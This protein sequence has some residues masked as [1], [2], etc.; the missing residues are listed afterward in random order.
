MNVRFLK[1]MIP[2]WRLFA[3]IG[4]IPCLHY[5]VG[6][7]NE[8]GEWIPFPNRSAEGGIND[9]LRRSWLSLFTN[10]QGNLVHA[11]QTLFTELMLETQTNADIKTSITYALVKNLVQAKAGAAKYQFK[12]SAKDLMTQASEEIL[13]SPLYERPDE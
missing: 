9:K 12:L 5:R 10:P 2:S 13:V 11:Y 1:V 3:D 6:H 4:H 7:G 8:L